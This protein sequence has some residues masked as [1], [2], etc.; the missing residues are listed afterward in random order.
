MARVKV[1]PAQRKARPGRTG[2]LAKDRETHTA[3]RPGEMARAERRRRG[4]RPVRKP[5]RA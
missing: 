2:H 1:K 5:V 3:A 4:K